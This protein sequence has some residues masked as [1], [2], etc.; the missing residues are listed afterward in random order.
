VSIFISTRALETNIV[1]IAA[2]FYGHYTGQPALASTY[3]S[4]LEDFVSEKFCCSHALADGNIHKV[5]H[6]STG[7]M[8]TAKIMSI[9]MRLHTFTPW[10][11]Y[12]KTPIHLLIELSGSSKVAEED[13]GI[14]KVAVSTTL[15]RLISKYF[16]NQQTLQA[17]SYTHNEPLCLVVWL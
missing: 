17:Q 13:V 2:T 3:S 4:E 8:L 9:Y 14:A 1:H 16:S 15:C 10:L 5:L 12:T 7:F 6:K 11:Q